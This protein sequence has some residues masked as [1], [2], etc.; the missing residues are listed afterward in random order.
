[1]RYFIN[2]L[3]TGIERLSNRTKERLKQAITAPACSQA[4]V[5]NRNNPI[6]PSAKSAFS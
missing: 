3:K 2:G 5:Q 4:R 1:M 6:H